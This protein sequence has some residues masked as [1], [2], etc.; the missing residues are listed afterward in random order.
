[1]TIAH[2]P[3]EDWIA[4]YVAGALDLGQHVA[5]ATHLAACPACRRFA[6]VL[7]GVGGAMIAEAAPAALAEGAF[8][9]TVLRLG[10]PA[11]PAPPLRPEESDAPSNLPGFVRRYEFGRW[12]R[13]APRVAMRPIVL[14]SPSPT[15]VFLLKAGAEAKLLEHSHDGVEMT[16]VL[17]GAFRRDGERYGPGDFDTGEGLDRH[18]PRIEPGEDCVSLVALSGRLRWR[19]FL[20][21][22]IGPFIRL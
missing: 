4:A 13:L 1:M 5:L 16:C 15:R 7:E 9:R 2:H 18:V 14:P 22:L 11:S 6:R 8:E 20:G 3:G 17:E 21:R 19:G 12:R 10:E